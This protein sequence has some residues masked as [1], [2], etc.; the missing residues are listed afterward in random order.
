MVY[1]RRTGLGSRGKPLD[2]GP[3]PRGPT[4]TRGG[5]CAMILN[6]SRTCRAGGRAVAKAFSGSESEVERRRSQGSFEKP[7]QKGRRHFRSA[8]FDN[9]LLLKCRQPGAAKPRAEAEL[10]RKVATLLR[11][12]SVIEDGQ[13]GRL[14]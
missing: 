2:I 8:G 9:L 3:L 4:V 5:G 6:R 10:S 1:R 14:L 7:L 13:P 12:C 11:D